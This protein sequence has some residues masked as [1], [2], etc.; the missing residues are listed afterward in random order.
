MGKY[1]FRIFH[2]RYAPGTSAE[3]PACTRVTYCV[4]GSAEIKSDKQ[5]ALATDQACHTSSP[6]VVAV[7]AEDTLVWRWEFI[8]AENV[9]D[10]KIRLD[11]VE[12]R[13]AGVYT[14]E[15][16]P[17]FPRMIRCDRVNFP[18]GGIAYHHIH[19]GPG[20]RSLLT[21]SLYLDS[22]G[23][24]W[25]GTPGSTWIEHGPEEVLAKADDD[26]PS[27]FVRVMVI[28]R[29]YK[30]KSTITYVR[31]EEADLPRVQKYDRYLD[32]FIDI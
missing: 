14:L 17:N 28:P 18:P 23:R 6:A 4:S 27:S 11:G 12:S 20:V 8:R 13:N 7:G 32:E 24:Q 26:L 2:D 10:G 5:A 30:G 16:D 25:Q 15:M 21:G 19:A 29:A 9:F 22:G 1:V 3:L 31:P